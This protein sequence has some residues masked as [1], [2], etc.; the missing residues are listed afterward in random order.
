MLN[1][2]GSLE[3]ER[4][5]GNEDVARKIKIEGIASNYLDRF[6][7]DDNPSTDNGYTALDQLIIYDFDLASLDEVDFYNQFQEL[8]DLVIDRT[9]E[10]I[11]EEEDDPIDNEC[12]G[13]DWEYFEAVDLFD[14]DRVLTKIARYILLGYITDDVLSPFSGVSSLEQIIAY[15]YGEMIN[16]NNNVREMARIRKK[17]LAIKLDMKGGGKIYR[18]GSLD[19]FTDLNL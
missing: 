11:N 1:G 5:N 17:L 2:T 12:E 19:E 10:I 13:E 4:R 9:H 6:I 8:K 14:E 3:P 15:E 7:T 18:N 16:A